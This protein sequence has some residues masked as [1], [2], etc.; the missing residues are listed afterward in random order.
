MSKPWFD[1]HKNSHGYSGPVPT[2]AGEIAPISRLLLESYQSKGF[3]LVPDMFSTGETPH[4]CG[5]ATRTVVDGVR[6]TATRYILKDNPLRNITIK[7]GTLVSKIVVQKTDKVALAIGVEAITQDGK[8]VFQAKKEVVLS[9][10]AYGS[11]AIL[12]RSGIGPKEEVEKHGINPLID[13]PGVG[14]NLMDHLVSTL[15]S[16]CVNHGLLLIFQR[17]CGCSTR[18]MS[19]D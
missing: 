15:K 4:A 5:F 11:P 2:S 18:L 12:L 3:P 10:G 17:L 8:F 19:L 6:T 14:K 16:E 9:A 7:T 1:E 13:L